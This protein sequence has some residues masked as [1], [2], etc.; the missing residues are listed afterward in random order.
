MKNELSNESLKAVK[1]RFIKESKLIQGGRI[2]NWRNFKHSCVIG[3]SCNFSVGFV[4]SVNSEGF[5]TCDFGR[6][7]DYLR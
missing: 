5:N 7:L 1:D 4:Y 6:Q 2:I 3:T